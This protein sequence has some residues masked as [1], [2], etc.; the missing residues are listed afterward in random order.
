MEAIVAGQ[1]DQAS[2]AGREWIEN[3]DGC[4]APYL[5]GKNIE[6]NIG[7]KEE[8]LH[9]QIVKNVHVWTHEMEESIQRAGQS[10]EA[11]EENDEHHIGKCHGHIDHL[12]GKR[13]FWKLVDWKQNQSNQPF[14]WFWCL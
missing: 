13:Y 6:F 11:N 10:Y 9:I 14:R 5:L 4:V 12:C 1:G 2:S 7:G 8:K 3:L